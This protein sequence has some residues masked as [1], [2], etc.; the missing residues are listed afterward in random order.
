MNKHKLHIFKHFKRYQ[1]RGSSSTPQ[2][3]KRYILQNPFFFKT[4]QQQQPC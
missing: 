2:T 3:Y 4:I 1:H